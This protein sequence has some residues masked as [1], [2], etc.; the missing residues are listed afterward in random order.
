MQQQLAATTQ[1]RDVARAEAG[2]LSEQADAA[3]SS[4]QEVRTA[5]H[6]SSLDND[7]AVQDLQQKLADAQRLQQ[8]AA[9]SAA[10]VH[11][12]QQHDIVSVQQRLE[13]ALAQ[14]ESLQGSNSELS[15]SVQQLRTQLELAQAA[16]ESQDEDSRIACMQMRSQIDI[17]QQQ[18]AA[19]ARGSQHQ[20]S[21]ATA[22]KTSVLQQGQDEE[23]TPQLRQTE[24]AGASSMSD[25][26]EAAPSADLMQLM[27]A[28]AEAAEHLAAKDSLAR[29]LLSLKSERAALQHAVHAVRQDLASSE[30]AKAELSTRVGS[31]QLQVR[32]LSKHSSKMPKAL[33]H[34]LLHWI[35]HSITLNMAF[36]CAEYRIPLRWIRHF[37]ML[38]MAFNSVPDGHQELQTA[39]SCDLKSC[40]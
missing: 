32:C 22:S 28:Q 4:R 12:Q 11:Q 15:A 24:P 6:Q 40:Q 20:K 16:L 29:Q 27:E 9:A 19:S 31:L 3:E 39:C 17:L 1:S 38:N 26:G 34:V 35:R 21:Q 8:Q 25:G 23:F 10:V 7:H 5:L 30:Q 14:A 18:L 36:H 2:V 33:R 37:R 13:R